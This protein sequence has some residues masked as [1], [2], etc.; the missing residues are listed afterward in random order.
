M[1][2]VP[3]TGTRKWYRFF[4]ARFSYQLHLV[5]KFLVPETNM[6]DDTVAVA[7]V[8]IIGYVSPRSCWQK[9]AAGDIQCCSSYAA[10]VPDSPLPA[11]VNKRYR[12][13]YGHNWEHSNTRKRLAA[14]LLGTAIDIIALVDIMER[15]KTMKL[16]TS[17]ST[18]EFWRYL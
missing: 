9:S 16:I 17:S 3:E 11:A 18:T 2:H 13:I 4:S 10:V 6:A 5:S 7:A 1:T 8:G 14:V 12:P 15:H